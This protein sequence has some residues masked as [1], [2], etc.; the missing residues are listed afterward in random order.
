MHYSSS[1]ESKTDKTYMYNYY[2][3]GDNKMNSAYYGL[4]V[5]ANCRFLYFFNTLYTYINYVFMTYTFCT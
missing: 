1:T 4:S 5:F 2:D 3:E